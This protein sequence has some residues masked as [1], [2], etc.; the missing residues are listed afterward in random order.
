MDDFDKILEGGI[1]FKG[2]SKGGPKEDKVKTKA[3]KRNIS[4][5]PTAPARQSKK[6]NTASSE[7]TESRSANNPTGWQV[8]GCTYILLPHA[9]HAT[10]Q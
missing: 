4:P 8:T 5:G 1:T 2:A 10:R 7:P 9:G 3:K 6:P